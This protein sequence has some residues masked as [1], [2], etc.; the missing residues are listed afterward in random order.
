[1]QNSPRLIQTYLP[2]GTLEGPRIIELSGSSIKAF[3]IPR[4]QL[5]NIRNRAELTQ[6]SLYFLVSGDESLG[7]YRRER[8]L[9]PSNARSRSKEGFLG[10]SYSDCFDC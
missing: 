1:M 7:L 6:P 9:Y 8:K 10:C 5:A 4:L 3:V 2:S